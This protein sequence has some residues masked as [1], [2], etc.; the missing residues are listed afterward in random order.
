MFNWMNIFQNGKTRP[1]QSNW[2]ACIHIFPIKRESVI[3]P[4]SPWYYC[5]CI[6]A[7]SAVLQKYC[8][9]INKIKYSMAYINY[10]YCINNN[11]YNYTMILYI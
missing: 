2:K 3:P 11:H 10:Q 6:N 4:T 5:E 7:K 8:D 9:Y 1:N